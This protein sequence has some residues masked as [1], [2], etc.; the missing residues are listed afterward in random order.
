MDT[1]TQVLADIQF[2]RQSGEFDPKPGQ[3]AGGGNRIFGVCPMMRYVVALNPQLT[4]KDWVRL[5]TGAGYHGQTAA[6]QFRQSREH[7]ATYYGYAVAA[8]GSMNT[9][10]DTRR[11]AG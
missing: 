2:A 5:A 1:D 11:K 10:V 7:D 4:R 6:K 9:A 3:V 8:D